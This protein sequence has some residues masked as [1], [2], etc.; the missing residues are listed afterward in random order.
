MRGFGGI[1]SSESSLHSRLIV[2][3][4]LMKSTRIIANLVNFA[5]TQGGPPD[6]GCAAGLRHEFSHDLSIGISAP[7][8]A[9]TRCGSPR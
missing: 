8:A 4:D 7:L 9:P 1:H 3:A 2:E 5:S 6:W